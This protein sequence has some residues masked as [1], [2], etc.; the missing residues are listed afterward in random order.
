MI[1]W[2]SRND[3]ATIAA[4]EGLVDP[5]LKCVSLWNNEKPIAVITYYATHPQSYYGQGDVTCEFVGIARNR[6]ETSLGGLPHIHFNGAGG[7]I[8]TGKY[9]DGSEASRQALAKRLETAMQQAWEQT[10]KT[11]TPENIAWKSTSVTLPLGKNIVEEKLRSTLSNE[12]SSWQEKISA[13]EKLAWYQ[14]SKEGV[15]INVSSL[16]LGKLWL[17]NLPG[18]LFVEYQLAAQQMK[19]GEK[20]CT[21]A[22]EELGPGYIGTSIAYTQGG[23]ETTDL[24]SG[25]APEVETVL[26][27][28]IKTVLK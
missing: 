15:K 11:T 5:W 2:S 21:A 10:K 19:P 13:A 23:Y 17:L 26:L 12:K 27:N 1:R 25:V 18:E 4:P 7:N 9:N 16:R 14:R 3:S 28:A 24:N 20:V 8:T 22:Y 6:R